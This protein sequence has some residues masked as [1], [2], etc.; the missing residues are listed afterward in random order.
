MEAKDA[1]PYTTL[2]AVQERNQR[3][4]EETRAMT[5]KLRGDLPAW[6][7]VL[8]LVGFMAMLALI[9]LKHHM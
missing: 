9:A 5:R 6:V 3:I 4:M 2:E 1:R 7:V 8:V